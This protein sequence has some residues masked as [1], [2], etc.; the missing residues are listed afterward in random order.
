MSLTLEEIGRLSSDLDIF[1]AAPAADPQLI[2]NRLYPPLPI[3]AELLIWGFSIV[4]TARSLSLKRLSCQRLALHSRGE[5]LAMA[6]RLEN[7]AGSYTW[8][9]KEKMLSFLDPGSRE[10]MSTGEFS[11]LIEGKTNPSLTAKVRTFSS[12][13]AELKSLVAAG[14]I[15][16]K[17]AHR[18]GELPPEV[19]RGLRDCALTF[20][21]RRQFLN[22]LFEIAR[23]GNLSR[24]RIAELCGRALG[25]DRPLEEIHRLRF[26]T[27]SSLEQRFAALRE[28]LVRG[29]GVS[30]RAPLNFEGDSFTVGFKFNSR[31]SLARKLEILR[32][33]EGRC[34][35][36]FELLH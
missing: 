7:R 10:I 4:R 5:M 20:S 9:E 35:A 27:T 36:L 22:E 2:L 29:S 3:C 33:L 15:D 26:P 8:P 31:K 34:D 11:A 28:E 30:L 19:F 12:L 17:S 6:L 16:L 32:A 21:E 14:Q 18:V 25:E 24:E 13:P 1:A 23:R